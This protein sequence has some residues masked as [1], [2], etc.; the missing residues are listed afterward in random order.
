MTPPA[1]ISELGYKSLCASK[2]VW[3]GWNAP[4]PLI[5][6]KSN[7]VLPGLFKPRSSPSGARGKDQIA[8]GIEDLDC[9]GT[10][11]AVGAGEM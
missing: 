4:N 3:C 9:G 5:G 11:E 7:F 2:R 8:V 10:L 1:A 6:Q